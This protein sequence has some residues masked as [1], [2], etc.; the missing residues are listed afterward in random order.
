MGVCMAKEGKCHARHT[1]CLSNLVVASDPSSPVV[2]NRRHFTS[3]LQRSDRNQL[4]EEAGNGHAAANNS[5]PVVS[6][7]DTPKVPVVFVL[8]N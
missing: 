8:G 4:V 5:A 6:N 3:A 1:E 2:E 7:F